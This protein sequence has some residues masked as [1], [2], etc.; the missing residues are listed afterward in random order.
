MS[1]TTTSPDAFHQ[2]RVVQALLKSSNY[3]LQQMEHRAHN[4]SVSEYQL[5]VLQHLLSAEVNTLPSLPLIEQQ[6]EI[7]LSMRPLLLDFLFEV[8][9]ILNLSRST[10]PLTVNLI[11]RY[12][13]TR[14]VK[15]QHYQLLGLTSLWISCKN[16]D[17]KFKIPTLN[18]L[19]KICVDSYN[20][21]LFIEMEKHI[22]KSLEWVVNAPTCDSF[23]DHF[24]S[25]LLAVGDSNSI[26][27]KQFYQKIRV[28]AYYLGE[29]FQ[30]YPNMY[31]DYTSS[32][33]AILAI[34]SSISMLKLSINLMTV[35]Q[36]Y[37]AILVQATQEEQV[38]HEEQPSRILAIENFQQ[39]FKN[40]R[41]LTVPNSLQQ[42]YAMY[43]RGSNGHSHNNSNNNNNNNNIK[44]Q[45][46]LPPKTPKVSMPLT[47]GPSPEEKFD[48]KRR[49]A[50]DSVSEGQGHGNATGGTLTAPA[51]KRQK[52]CSAAYTTN[53]IT[54][55]N[56][57]SNGHGHGHGHDNANGNATNYRV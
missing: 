9:T 17:S 47:P 50:L 16:L 4:N 27:I 28:T 19:R 38:T 37:N 57:N 20:K 1:N 40:I 45:T 29:L 15:K 51:L 43:G 39:V 42:K 33:I 34:M 44:T 8:I 23:I 13:S 12:C 14:I 49:E 53:A 24:L 30:F 54:N 7:K 41:F 25:L 35:L 21:E 5:D 31:F 10:F 48:R 55:T 6:P 22:L 26:V 2:T 3:K 56:T 11:D 32:Q 36:F 18:D 46:L 52:S